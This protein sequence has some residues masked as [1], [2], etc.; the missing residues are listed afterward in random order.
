MSTWGRNWGYDRGR[1]L[2]RPG[3]FPGAPAHLPLLTLGIPGQAEQRQCIIKLPEMSKEKKGQQE[4]EAPPHPGL[5]ALCKGEGAGHRITSDRDTSLRP[6]S[7]GK[8]FP[9]PAPQSRSSVRRGHTQLTHSEIHGVPL[10]QGP[11]A[12]QTTALIVILKEL[13]KVW[14]EGGAAMAARQDWAR[15]PGPCPAPPPRQI[16]N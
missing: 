9:F 6:R 15:A 3:S 10:T 4:G 11:K 2:A 16:L 7:R 8:D 5:E 14:G 12:V 13:H 1:T